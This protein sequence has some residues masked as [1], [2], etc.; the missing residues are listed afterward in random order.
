MVSLLRLNL[1]TSHQ[2]PTSRTIKSLL[3]LS[4][5]HL[6]GYT[7]LEIPL[8]HFNKITL[9]TVVQM[10]KTQATGGAI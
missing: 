4:A 5:R 8:W 7:V 9:G 6:T 3:T 1:T 10:E 2:K